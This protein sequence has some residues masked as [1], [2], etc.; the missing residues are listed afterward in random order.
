LIDEVEP[1]HGARGLI[2]DLR[3]EGSTVILA[4][5]AKQ[6]EIDHYLDLLAAR[7]LVDG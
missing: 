4:S 2:E 5:S 7:D 1:M 6:D 3:E